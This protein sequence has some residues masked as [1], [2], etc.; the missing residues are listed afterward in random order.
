[1]SEVNTY[2]ILWV[3]TQNRFYIGIQ[4]LKMPILRTRNLDCI[5]V[6]IM[7]L[8]FNWVHS[9]AG[10]VNEIIYHVSRTPS[11][12]SIPFPTRNNIFTWS[13]LVTI[14]ILVDY[15]KIPIYF[16]RDSFFLITFKGKSEVFQR[17]II[18]W[19]FRGRLPMKQR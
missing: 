7:F 9:I 2:W 16:L 4:I 15:A 19:R 1:M 18:P 11:I 10:T 17:N 3:H 12:E 8:L 13:T 14:N 6:I 5:E